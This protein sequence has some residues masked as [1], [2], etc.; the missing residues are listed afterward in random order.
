MTRPTSPMAG[1]QCEPQERR[2]CASRVALLENN[3]SH[4]EKEVESGIADIKETLKSYAPLIR[5]RALELI[6]Y[7]A[8]S[9]LLSK[10]AEKVF[11][12]F[13]RMPAP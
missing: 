1:Q 8:G 5:L 7:G 13:I 10:F 11:E 4:L 3:L 6:I 9:I 12:F 2:N